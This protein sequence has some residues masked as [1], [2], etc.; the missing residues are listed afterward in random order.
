M[1]AVILCGGMGTR[2]KE[3]DENLPKP[4]LDIGG[5]PILLHIM[6]SYAA[7][8]ITD[9]VLCLGYKGHVVRN[10]FLNYRSFNR[11][12]TISLKEGNV[13]FHGHD[14][15]EDWNVTLADTG[16]STQTGGRI[17]KIRDYVGDETFHLTYGD[18][19]SDVDIKALGKHHAQSGAIATVTAVKSVGR[20]GEL[21]CRPDG[22]VQTFCEKPAASAG[23][24]SGGFF[25]LDGQ[26]LWSYFDNNP[27][28]V[29]E[30]GPL[31]K[32]AMDSKLTAY[33]HDGFWQCMDT[34]REHEL[35]NKL[36]K[37][38]KAP[39]KTW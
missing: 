32:L 30:S 7:H 12:C 22:I 17:F 29:F 4:L 20:F 34:P 35:L 18:A 6:K 28:L 33:A 16:E 21:T 8:G 25:V 39:W 11:D 5:N 26:R 15:I 14:A 13:R 31:T 27:D 37:E 3:V 36:W 23:R 9:F 24:I 19:V 2:I 38:K 10:Y 1:K